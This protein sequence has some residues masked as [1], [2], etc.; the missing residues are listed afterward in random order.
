MAKYKLLVRAENG[1]YTQWIQ[2]PDG[3]RYAT[4]EKDITFVVESNYPDR[5]DSDELL[6]QNGLTWYK[7]VGKPCGDLRDNVNGWHIK[8]I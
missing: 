3:S 7:G 6:K 4:N 2:K 5:V 1:V 8:V